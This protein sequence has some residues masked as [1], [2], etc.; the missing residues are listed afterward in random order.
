MGLTVPI[1]LSTAGSGDRTVKLQK[2]GM[3][4]YDHNAGNA[5]SAIRKKPKNQLANGRINPTKLVRHTIYPSI[6]VGDAI[7]GS[8]RSSG[9]NDANTSYIR[10]PATKLDESAKS[11]ITRKGSSRIA[12]GK[13]KSASRIVS[14]P[15]RGGNAARKQRKEKKRKPTGNEEAMFRLWISTTRERIHHLKAIRTPEESHGTQM[16]ACETKSQGKVEETMAASGKCAN[17]VLASQRLEDN[18]SVIGKRWLSTT[19]SSRERNER[20]RPFHNW[21]NPKYN[22]QRLF[23]HA[24]ELC[25]KNKN[26]NAALNRFYVP[27]SRVNRERAVH[28]VNINMTASCLVRQRDLE[29]RSVK[30][31]DIGRAMAGTAYTLALFNSRSRNIR[32]SRIPQK[33]DHRVTVPYFRDPNGSTRRKV[34][35]VPEADYLNAKLIAMDGRTTNSARTAL[36]FSRCPSPGIICIRLGR[37]KEHH[38]YFI[39]SSIVKS[40]ANNMAMRLIRTIGNPNTLSLRQEQKGKTPSP[41]A[42]H[43]GLSAVILIV[44]L[45]EEEAC[46]Q[47]ISSSSGLIDAAV[48]IGLGAFRSVAVHAGFPLLLP[49]LAKARLLKSDQDQR[50]KLSTMDFLRRTPGHVHHC[51]DNIIRA[52]IFSSKAFLHRNSADCQSFGVRLSVI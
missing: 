42:I 27:I 4:K 22:K 31:P 16:Y 18:C 45:L 7:E 10:I 21:L 25:S 6:G 38:F 35:A 2:K 3:K 40:T 46:L 20:Q 39:L 43:F 41:S 5:Q 9:Q 52:Q 44:F 33:K 17:Q 51:L 1:L 24:E 47:F 30:P 48:R 19:I 11:A 12:G 49:S 14:V 23:G 15:K 13:I 8:R 29:A 50:K 28:G 37:I 36:A 34:G 26:R 32:V